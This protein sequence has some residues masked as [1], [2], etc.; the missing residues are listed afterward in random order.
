MELLFD[1][2]DE[3]VDRDGDPD[4]GLHSVLGGAEETLDT[5]MLL[6]PFEKQFDLP[7]ALVE[8]ANGQRREL[9]VVGQ[10]HERLRRFGSLETDP[11]ELLRVALTGTDAVEQNRLVAYQACGPIGRCRVEAPHIRV[12]FGSGDEKCTCLSKRIE[13]LEIQI[14]AVHDIE[15]ASLGDQKVETVDVVGFPLGDVEKTR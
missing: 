1:D 11:A 9:K 6:D 5:E 8:S 12:R 14:G 10:K 13:P 4:L 15:R 7:T 3:H 2:G